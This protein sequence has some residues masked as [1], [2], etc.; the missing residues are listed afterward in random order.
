MK[1]LKVVRSIDNRKGRLDDSRVVIVDNETG[2]EELIG[3]IISVDME[4]TLEGCKLTLVVNEKFD[5]N[6]E[7]FQTEVHVYNNSRAE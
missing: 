7:F 5:M 3:G 1:R 2:E 4:M 6:L